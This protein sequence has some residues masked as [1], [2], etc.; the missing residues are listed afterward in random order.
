MVVAGNGMSD[1]A[2]FCVLLRRLSDRRGLDIH[3]LSDVAELPESEVEAVLNGTVPSS[4]F[5]QRIAPA[6]GLHAADLFVIAGVPVPEEMAPL[7]SRAGALVPVLAQYAVG[8]SR[9]S[10]RRLLEIV[11]SLPQ[12]DRTQPVPEPKVYERYPSGFGGMLLRML[13]NRN[14]N[15]WNSAAAL[16]RLTGGRVYLSAST[17]GLVGRGRKE[18]TPDLLGGFAIVLGM[19]TDDLAALGEIEIAEEHSSS[20]NPAL[21]DAAELIWEL[22]RLTAEQVRQLRDETNSMRLE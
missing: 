1:L 3:D 10:R 2:A 14:L 11:R 17:V 9:E 4:S 7:D 12:H 21:A 5:L 6:L 22:R 19:P 18:I 16:A 20:A 8:L 13:G 15:L